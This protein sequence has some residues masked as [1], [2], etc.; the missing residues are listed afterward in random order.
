MTT[1]GATSDAKVVKTTIPCFHIQKRVYA[2][3]AKFSSLIEPGYKVS[4]VFQWRGY[5]GKSGVNVISIE[6]WKP[7]KTVDCKVNDP[8]CLFMV[9]K[10]MSFYLERINSVATIRFP[11]I[12]MFDKNALV[13]I[14]IPWSSKGF[15]TQQLPR[16]YGRETHIC[17]SKLGAIDSDNGLSPVRCQ[18]IIWTNAGLILI[19][20]LGSYLGEIVVKAIFIQEKTLEMSSA[21][22]KPFYPGL[23]VLIIIM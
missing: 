19:G 7:N 2:I 12:I 4:F 9:H 14:L 16:H 15:G 11:D 17:V 10:T 1:H 18:V 20:P 5:H 6:H 22:Q 21:K 23:N 3:I 8:R 13:W